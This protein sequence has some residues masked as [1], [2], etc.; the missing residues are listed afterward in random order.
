MEK[1]INHWDELCPNNKVLCEKE[2]LTHKQEA[3]ERLDSCKQFVLFT[4]PEIQPVKDRLKI[5]VVGGLS[6]DLIVAVIK[7]CFFILRRVESAKARFKNE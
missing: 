4:M 2:L 1:Q 3:K 5:E 7:E 6:E